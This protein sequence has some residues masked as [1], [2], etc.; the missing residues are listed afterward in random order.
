MKIKTVTMLLA[1]SLV[2][3]PL[4]A[5][6]GSIDKKLL[7]NFEK[8]IDNLSNV[9]QLI[10]M[11]TNNKIA[12]LSLNHGKVIAHN[13]LFNHTLKSTKISNQ[14]SSGRCWAFAGGNLITPKVMSKLQLSDFQISESFIAFYDKLEKGNYFLERVI[15]LRER[16]LDDRSLQGVFDSFFGDGGWMHYFIDLIK[17]YGVV[18]KEIMPETKQSSA[19]SSLNKLGKMLLRSFAAELLEMHHNGENEKAL[20]KRKEEMLTEL[21]KFLVLNY[22][23]PPKTFTYRYEYNDKDDTTKTEKV[24]IEQEYTP[25]TFFTEFYG[26]SMPEYVAIVHNP[27]MKYETRYLMENSRN[28]YESED[29]DVINLP[30]D[31]LKKYARASILDSQA[32]W[33][34]CDVGHENYKKGAIMDVDIYD[35]NNTLDLDFKMTKKERLLYGEIAPTHAMVLTGLD[36][37][38][39]GETVKWLVENS[40]GSKSGKDGFWSMYDDWFDE[41]LLLII[42]DKNMLSEKD[43]NLF[44]SKP[45]MIKDWQ[46]FFLALRN[47]E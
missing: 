27:T 39:N 21:Y 37:A 36:T 16:P 10:N 29:F 9:D 2:S 25:K 34:A 6:D 19:T 15:E 38:Q 46:P 17:K 33:F 8:E 32:V 42:V 28:I 26:S 20:R 22:G 12:D 4:L 44:D 5:K 43:K 41:Y 23:K 40:W 14:K 31:D 30:I 18:P 3:L 1:I 13:K 45:K 7:N 24:I 47:L 35:Y 11:V